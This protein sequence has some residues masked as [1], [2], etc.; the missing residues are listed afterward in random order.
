VS[1]AIIDE[2][3]WRGL[4]DQV[5]DEARVR[6]RLRDA[7]A[8]VYCGFDP[9]AASLQVGNLV[10][11][12]G[13]ARFQQ[14]GHRPIVLLGGGTGLI[15]DPRQT[16]ERP[17]NDAET[18]RALAE[19]IRPQL[20]RFVSFDGA[21]AA[22]L[23]DN[24]DWLGELSAVAFLRD[25]GK[26][27]PIGYMLAKESVKSRLEGGISYTEFSYMLMQAY[28]Y[29]HLSRRYGCYLQVGGSDQWGNITA[30]C[31]LIRRVDAGLADALTFP[32]VT[33][34][35]GTKFGKS[36]GGAVYLDATLTSPYHFYQFWL[37][38][39]DRDAGRFLRTFTFLDRAEIER[40]EASMRQAPDQR[41]AQR[42]LARSF[43]DLVHGVAVRARI[44]QVSAA[45]FGQQRISE[46]DPEAFAVAVDA[47]PTVRVADP[48]P[49]IA[50]LL[51]ATSLAASLSEARRLVAAGGVYANDD[52]V[53]D[54]DQPPA[55]E[56]FLGGRI[57]VLRRGRR[58]RGLVVRGG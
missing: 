47:V 1:D 48:I 11:L 29:L 15:G 27:F 56:A 54:G 17:L 12:L 46:T 45:L 55:A 50:Q 10:P 21:N 43:T 53:E 39:D 28:D 51:V 24:H 36:E 6:A 18:V 33:K 25:V 5:T 30:G 41:A 42:A 34:A 8:F 58:G 37:A 52:R 2:L 57:L 14:A 40:L 16:G 38:T 31:E 3:Q 13:L 7:P 44:E 22:I 26:H 19:R 9:T 32:L 49:T 20:A 35:D 23:V 4:V